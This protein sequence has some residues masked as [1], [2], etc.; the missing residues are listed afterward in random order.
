MR[1]ATQQLRTIGDMPLL[2]LLVLELG[3]ARFEFEQFRAEVCDALFAFGRFVGD[4]LD[5]DGALVVIERAGE[6]GQRRCDLA[7]EGGI[8]AWAGGERGQVGADRF[9]L[10]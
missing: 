8:G 10:P 7:L 1:S 5:V 4:K 3:E 6:G 9:G 2:F